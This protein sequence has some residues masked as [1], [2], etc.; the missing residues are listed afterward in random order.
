[1]VPWGLYVAALAF[2]L[3]V[4][5]S[6]AAREV[7]EADL[8]QVA[9]TTQASTLAAPRQLAVGLGL[10]AFV[11]LPAAATHAAGQLE[12]LERR[13][14][15]DLTPFQVGFERTFPLKSINI[16]LNDA[17][18]TGPV[19]GN[20]YLEING[21]DVTWS[22]LIRV[23]GAFAFRI[24]LDD[25]VLPP[26]ARIWI[27]NTAGESLGP[28]DMGDIDAN[29][30]LWLPPL[31][32]N[33]IYV[34]ITASVEDLEKGAGFRFK[35]RQISE[36]VPF[37][38]DDTAMDGYGTP[39]A[40]LWTDCD[41][42]I[43]CEAGAPFD[44]D[45]QARAVARLTFVNDSGGSWLCSGALVN[46][47]IPAPSFIPYLLTANHCFDSPTEAASL[48]SYFDYRSS[49]CGG[50][51]PGLG[52]V[53]QVSGSTLLATGAATDFTFVEL[54]QLP[55]G[56]RT[57]LGWS[58]ADPV[59]DE[60]L[61]RISHPAGLKAYY[62]TQS[63]N[64]SEDI[65]CNGFER[66]N[67]HYSSG[68]TGSTSGG[69]SGA[70]VYD[71]SGRI[72]GQLYGTCH[73]PSWDA[74]SYSTFEVLD[75]AFA[76][77]YPSIQSWINTTA[78]NLAVTTSGSGSGM[79]TSSPPGIE[80]GGD[81]SQ[82]YNAG[83]LV[84]LTAIPD[85]GSY[86]AG[87]SGSCA[88]IVNPVDVS[89]DADKSCNAQ[90][91]PDVTGPYQEIYANPDPVGAQPGGPARID[92]T[93]D[94]SDADATLSGIG[95]RVHY[96][97][98]M[99]TYDSVSNSIAFGRLFDEGLV[100]SE[101]DVGD[102]DSDASTDR[103]VSLEWVDFGGGWPGSLPESLASVH[104]VTTGSFTGSTQVNFSASDLAAGYA[105]AVTPATIFEQ[106]CTLDTDDNGSE[107][108]LTD[109]V[110]DVRYLFG[111]TGSQLTDGAIGAGATRTDAASIM[112]YLGGCSAML[113]VDGNGSAGALT[114]GVLIVRYLF[115]FT[116]AQL[117]DGAVGAG[118]TRCD[119]TSIMAFLTGGF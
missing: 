13:R 33:D 39:N 78:Y 93:Y 52:N 4:P 60:S 21:A 12:A 64:V 67:F 110:L 104:F 87:W 107:G 118:C 86:F 90:F 2:G 77:T 31:E 44:I 15:Q 85:A 18:V 42:D 116:G 50:D 34:E 98:T 30:G 9:G 7:V 82:P 27:Y 57:L 68:L 29:G 20:Q 59:A 26:S 103:F 108:A 105:L 106:L 48:V 25:M 88:G 70:P 61:Y 80:C 45:V 53:P 72:R 51:P 65:T 58:T 24:R 99:M 10:P 117:T 75:G 89:M 94:V 91:D 43:S 49:A 38:L 92:L 37:L 79:V 69:S 84:T 32:G 113:D 28:F 101:A 111:F 47:N 71:S 96:D 23:I 119:A 46:D 3:S 11:S 81:C 22:S 102:L 35:L 8:E 76:A 63:Y 97:S 112:S 16:T 83:R 55:S 73:L 54:D 114:D 56:D 66:A 100:I 5:V 36:L 17:L 1:M 14:R 109:G 115:G 40:N 74:C 19:S 41:I 95:I 6:G 62:S